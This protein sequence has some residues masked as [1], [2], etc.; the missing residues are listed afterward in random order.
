MKGIR[1][2]KSTDLDS[3]PLLTLEIESVDLEGRGVSRADGKV[4]FVDNGLPGER[5]LARI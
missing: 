1:R 2:R 3:A 5:V 4:V